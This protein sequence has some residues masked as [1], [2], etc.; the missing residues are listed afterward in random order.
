VGKLAVVGAQLFGGTLARWRRIAIAVVLCAFLI[1]LAIV[2][3]TI[4]IAKALETQIG[5][6]WA[7]LAVAVLL[8]VAA[9]VIYLVASRR[10]QASQEP[11]NLL[12][13][14]FGKRKPSAISTALILQAL[15]VGYS[16]AEKRP[17]NPK[18]PPRRRAPRRKDLTAG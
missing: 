7:S 5:P 3:F 2:Q 6:L 8:V 10:P 9:V 11:A 12:V 13:G 17:E 14:L 4:F 15:L 16:L 1:L 18:P